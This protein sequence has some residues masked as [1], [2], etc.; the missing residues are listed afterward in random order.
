M[1]LTW[2]RVF[3]H[4]LVLAGALTLAVL[5]VAAGVLTVLDSSQGAT[6]LSGQVI[7]TT[8]S[9]PEPVASAIAGRGLTGRTNRVSAV[10]TA[11]GPDMPVLG[12]LGANEVVD[13]DGRNTKGDWLRIVFPPNSPLHG[14]IE[15]TMVDANGDVSALAVA[16]PDPPP[17]IS[18]P[19]TPRRSSGPQPSATTTIA[20]PA[21]LTSPTS[22]TYRGVRTA[23]PTTRVVTGT[24][25]P[26]PS[27]QRPKPRC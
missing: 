4:R 20:P 15:A 11:P 17:P 7:A 19:T 23:T 25:T 26:C 10:R 13:I 1:P 12:T 14:W 16:T 22:S 21:A 8:T 6:P 3:Q 18:V 24:P 2:R 9:T 5:G 27:N